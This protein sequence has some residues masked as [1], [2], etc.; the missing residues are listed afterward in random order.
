VH[1]A[2]SIILFTSLTGVGYGAMI[3][4]GLL[5]GFGLLRLDPTHTGVAAVIAMTV[6]GIGLVC[7]TF[8]LRHPERAW[9]AF[10]QWRSSWL[11]REGVMALITFVPALAFA[12]AMIDAVEPDAVIAVLGFVAAVCAFITILCTAMIYRSL[13]TVP[14]WHNH[15]TVPCF[16][17]IGL[18]TGA[19]LLCAI[20][21]VG[22]AGTQEAPA[23][24]FAALAGLTLTCV[25]K[26]F[27]W[28]MVDV[29]KG[30]T[31]AASA[32]GLS[33]R[34]TSVRLLEAPSTSRNYL[35]KEMGFRI[36]RKHA[37]KLRRLALLL[38][39]ALPIVLL[40]LGFMSGTWLGA[41]LILLSVGAGLA[42]TLVER[43]LFFA[44]ATHKVTLYYGADSV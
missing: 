26:F 1:P 40:S 14:Q 19:L 24:A 6:V 4:L 36:A 5:H 22:S 17:I 10:S 43:W 28:R 44:E 42:G 27:A 37:A 38:G 32:V 29:A 9:R 13:W 31:D 8:H 33:G 35:Q 3:W 18:T 12:V 16:L 11:S 21:A 23:L 2:L 25:L 34:A 39:I 7:S 30:D 15:W 20:V 41:F